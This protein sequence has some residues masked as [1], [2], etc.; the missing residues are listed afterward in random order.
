MPL[1]AG[2]NPRDSPA[3]GSPGEPSR[4]NPAVGIMPQIM[5]TWRRRSWWQIESQLR[6]Q[7][8][9]SLAYGLWCMG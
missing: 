7:A 9:E 1:G 2:V 5:G 8:V 6:H 3:I 4:H